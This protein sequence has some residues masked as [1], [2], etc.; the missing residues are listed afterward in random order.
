MAGEAEQPG[1]W[2]IITP[3]TLSGLLRSL[4]VPWWVTG[5]WAIDP[6][7]AGRPGPTAISRAWSVP[8]AGLDGHPDRAGQMRRPNFSARYPGPCREYR[9]PTTRRENTMEQS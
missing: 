2:E 5:G 6:S 3:T 9:V 4:A 1:E 7:S 8:A